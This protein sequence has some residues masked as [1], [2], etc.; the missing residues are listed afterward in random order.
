MLF[1]FAC[2]SKVHD[3]LSAHH[4]QQQ[5]HFIPTDHHSAVEDRG[6]WVSCQYDL[7]TL[8]FMPLMLRKS[9]QAK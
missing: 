3:S 1:D 5:Q 6:L 8:G 7:I 9:G 2:I 4:P